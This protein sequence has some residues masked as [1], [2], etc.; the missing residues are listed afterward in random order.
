MDFTKEGQKETRP[1][2]CRR[3]AVDPSTSD[4]SSRQGMSSFHSHK[5]PAEEG[6]VAGGCDGFGWVSKMVVLTNP[7]AQRKPE[8]NEFW[9]SLHGNLSDTLIDTVF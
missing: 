3:G 1:I 2:E 4:Q 5:C 8:E 6:N 7:A 9:H